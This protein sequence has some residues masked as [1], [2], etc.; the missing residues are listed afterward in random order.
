MLRTDLNFEDEVD[1]D[2]VVDGLNY[3]GGNGRDNW[4]PSPPQQRPRRRR[5]K[6][7]KKGDQWI[8]GEISTTQ[9]IKRPFGDDSISPNKKLRL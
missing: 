8:R 6:W 2:V 5:I 4:I 3:I 9:K 1:R 7:I